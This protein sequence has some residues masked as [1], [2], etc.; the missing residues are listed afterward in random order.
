MKDIYTSAEG[1]RN[2]EPAINCNV[3]MELLR[4]RFI[5]GNGSIGNQIREIKKAALFRQ[6]SSYSHYPIVII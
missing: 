6:P 2:K 5:S 1:S 4:I 3:T